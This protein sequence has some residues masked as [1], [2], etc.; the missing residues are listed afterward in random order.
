MKSSILNTGAAVVKHK[1][2]MQSASDIQRKQK[3]HFHGR[4]QNREYPHL[5]KSKHWTAIH[6]IKRILSFQET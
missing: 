6:S 4:C 2:H 3:A 5:N 1:M